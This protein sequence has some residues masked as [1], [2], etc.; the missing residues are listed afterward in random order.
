M[1][2]LNDIDRFHLVLD[3]IARVPGLSQSEDGQR[4]TRYGDARLA[5]HHAYIRQRGDDMPTCA[6]GDGL[7]YAV[8][9]RQT[10]SARAPLH[11]QHRPFM[12][13]ER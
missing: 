4:T 12:H 8:S 3:V 11:P 7:A 5:E 10:D 13:R 1:T 2:V 6:I 9:G